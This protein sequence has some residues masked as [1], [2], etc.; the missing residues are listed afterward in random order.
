MTLSKSEREFHRKTAVTCF[1]KTWAYLEKNRNTD[2][3]QQMLHLAHASR[4]HWG[5]VGTPKNFAISDWQISRVYADLEQPDLALQF[6]KSSLEVCEKNNLSEFL[7][8]AYEGM[9]RAHAVARNNGA[10]TSYLKKARAQLDS[11]DIDKEDRKVYLDQ[12]RETEQL[13]AADRSLGKPLSR[14]QH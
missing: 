4:F 12:I 5:L 11:A 3:R 8:S 14:G 9:A 1:N 7:C 13:L 6:A 2:E 10:A